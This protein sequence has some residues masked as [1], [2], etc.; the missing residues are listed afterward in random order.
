MYCEIH[1]RFHHWANDS[2]SKNTQC[3]VTTRFTPGRLLRRHVYY[4]ET[5]LCHPFLP[6][7]IQEP[8]AILTDDQAHVCDYTQHVF[9]TLAQPQ[10]HMRPYRKWPGFKADCFPARWVQGGGCETAVSGNT[11]P[12]PIL[13]TVNRYILFFI[14]EFLYLERRVGCLVADCK[15][16]DFLAGQDF[17]FSWFLRIRRKIKTLIYFL[18]F[19]IAKK[20]LFKVDSDPY[21]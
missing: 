21:E 16:D 3:R 15:T 11:H 12:A 6:G 1:I 17:V 20:R 13:I 9:S 5:I 8:P 7:E 2:I 18:S 14:Q 10:S 4:T 19:S